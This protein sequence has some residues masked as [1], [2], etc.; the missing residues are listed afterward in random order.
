MFYY[1]DSFVENETE[2]EKILASSKDALA[3]YMTIINHLENLPKTWEYLVKTFK[4]KNIPLTL[5]NTEINFKEFR[6]LDDDQCFYVYVFKFNIFINS[7]II[8]GYK[9]DLPTKILQVEGEPI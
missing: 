2:L 4:T 8:T 7:L 9:K 1:H 6:L 5:S 3:S